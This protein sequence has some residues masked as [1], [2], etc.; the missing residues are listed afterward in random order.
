M[1][2]LTAAYELSKRGHQVSVFERGPVLGG[3]ASTFNVG[4]ARLERGYHHLF[5]NDY[6]FISLADELGLGSRIQWIPS[7]VGVFVNGRIFDFVTPLDLLKFNPI[8]LIDRVRLGLVALNLQRNR[9]WKKYEGITAREWITKWAGRRNYNVVWGPLLRGK[10]G[11]AADEVGMVWFWGKVFLRFASRKKGTGREVL[12][13]PIGSWGEIIDRLEERIRGQGGQIYTSCAV[14]RIAVNG[15][16]VVGLDI[17]SLAGSSGSSLQPFDIVVA[18]TPSNVFVRLLPE[19]PEEEAAKLRSVRYHAAILVVLVLKH[20]LSHIY[21][22]SVSDRSL[23][24]VAVIQ[25]TNFMPPQHYGGKHIVYLSNYLGRENPMYHMTPDELFNHYVPHLQR[26]NPRFDPSWIEERY[27]HREDAAQPIIT[28]NYL[29]R[30]PRVRTD[31]K[32]LYLCNTTHVYPEDRGTN[33]AV[34]LGRRVTQLILEDTGSGSL[35][36]GRN[37]IPDSYTS[38]AS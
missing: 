7:K 5:T 9:N 23:P 19:Y 35:K 26:I 36:L 11:D 13:Y 38:L 29:S 12:G 32:G 30:L 14:Q 4:G 18:T 17:P 8:S 10:F 15:E 3:Q 21:W 34:R 22:L 24:F 2:G 6:D 28:T 25:Q 1:L 37:A 20:P 31:F 16:R 33:Y 27:Y